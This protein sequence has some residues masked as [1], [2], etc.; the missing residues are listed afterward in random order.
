MASEG[1]LAFGPFRFLPTSLRL[2]RD[3]APVAMTSQQAQV[4]RVLVSRAG[5]VISKD[6]L[7]AAWDGVVVNGNRIERAA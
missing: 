7:I 4:L 1:G 2:L 6:A 5:E 3:D